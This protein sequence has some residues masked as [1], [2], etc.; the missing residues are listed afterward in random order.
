MKP[1]SA[2]G[3]GEDA[4]G[5]QRRADH[6]DEHDGVLDHQARVELFE[7]VAHGRADNVPVEKR[8]SFVCHTIAIK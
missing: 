1:R 8:R 2:G 5:G 6:R 3:A 7:R 4:D